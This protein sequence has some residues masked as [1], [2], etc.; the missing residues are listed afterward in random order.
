MGRHVIVALPDGRPALQQFGLL[1]QLA[2]F[3]HRDLHL[4]VLIA[5]HKNSPKKGRNP[6]PHGHLLFGGRAWDEAT[7][8]FAPQRIRSSTSVTG[9]DPNF[10]RRFAV[11]GSK[12]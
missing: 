8:T 2:E 4:P 3:L 7:M 10:W 6:N 5:M 9:K 12:S 1:K 11:S